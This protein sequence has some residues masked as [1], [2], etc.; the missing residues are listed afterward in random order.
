MKFCTVLVPV[1]THYIRYGRGRVICPLFILSFYT[2]LFESSSS[3]SH[4]IKLAHVHSLKEV[5]LK[6]K[7]NKT[8]NEGDT[9]SEINIFLAVRKE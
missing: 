4:F 1:Y 5:F 3:D 2:I 9:K 6:N 8:L 7:I